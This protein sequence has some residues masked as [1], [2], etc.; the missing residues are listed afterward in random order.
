MK[1]LA[2]I[3]LG[4]A[5][6]APTA[7]AQPAGSGAPAA[8]PPAKRPVL[9]PADPYAD[10]PKPKPGKP[11]D[12]YAGPRPPIPARPGKPADPY[13]EPRPPIAKPGKPLDP[14]A[15][16]PP[17]K[18]AN[19]Y[20][21]APK[22]KPGKPVD[23]YAEVPREGPPKIPKRIELADIASVQG[24]LAVQRL[25]GWLLFDRE[26]TNPIAARL[27]APSAPTT[28][29]WFYLVR[30]RGEPIVLAHESEKKSFEHLAGQKLAYTGYR[31]MEKQLRTA[32]KGMRT[33]AVEYSARATVP[34][35][36]RVD[37]GTLEL[38]RGTGVQVKSSHTLVQYTKAIWGEAGRTAHYIAAHHLTELRKEALSF[39][40][41]QIKNGATV[42]ELDV[43]QRLVRGMQ[44]RGLVGPPPVVATGANSA[45]PYYVTTAAKGAPI[46][47]GD[48]LVIALAGKLDKPDGVYAAQSW[49][50]AVD[51]VA[52]DDVKATFHA[53]AIARD[54]ALSLIAERTR[55]G[56]PVTGAEV[57]QAARGFLKKAGHGNQVLHRTGHSIDQELQGSGA[58]LDDLEVKD[59]RILTAGT[60]FTVGP[61][62]YVAGQYGVRTEVSVFLSPSGPEVTTP[63]QETVEPLLAP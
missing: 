31:E 16:A 34:S 22:A 8:K 24:L 2:A 42:N 7:S 60:G 46:R 5:L 49:V 47:R 17:A 21:D 26:G 10:P 55:R 13:G 43:Q 15:E 1:R 52:R 6:L 12:P 53:A 63:M 30:G 51:S 57:D 23:P 44:M 56:R 28:R 3:V 18:P 20:V 41:K 54:T 59:T 35:V 48:V 37:A 58:D 11:V 38:I 29:P 45:E 4:L 27:V 33:V 61:G 36:S 25:D 40:A 62:L 14:Y 32:L 19:P 9:K 50:A 39:V